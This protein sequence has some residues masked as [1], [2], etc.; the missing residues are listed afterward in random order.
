MPSD[1]LFCVSGGVFVQPDYHQAMFMLRMA[2]WAADNRGD[3][4]PIYHRISDRVDTL[5]EGTHG[6]DLEESCRGDT[7]SP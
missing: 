5:E 3:E 6:F 2:A 1:R 4:F 7:E